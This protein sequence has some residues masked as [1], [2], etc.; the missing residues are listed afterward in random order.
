MEYRGWKTSYK[1]KT[2]EDPDEK[3]LA[4][5]EVASEKIHRI[6]Y[7]LHGRKTHARSEEAIAASEATKKKEAG[8]PAQIQIF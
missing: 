8:Q 6:I 3:N 7:S 1:T 5:P 2:P 4:A